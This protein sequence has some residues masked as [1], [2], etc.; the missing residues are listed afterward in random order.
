MAR[1]R[2]IAE[3]H[4]EIIGKIIRNDHLPTP[5]TWDAQAT[6][7]PETPFSDKLYC[8]DERFGDRPMERRLVR[9]KG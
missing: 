7:S 3:K 2:N 9:A 8:D 1:G 4:L 6:D 5:S